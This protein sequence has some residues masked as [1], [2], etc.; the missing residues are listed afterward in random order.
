DGGCVCPPGTALA[1]QDMA[2]QNLTIP[3][4]AAFNAP[5]GGSKYSIVASKL[6]DLCS[7]KSTPE[8][9]LL[10]GGAAPSGGQIG[11][12]SGP[13]GPDCSHSNGDPHMLTVNG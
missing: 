1:G 2:Q 4:V 6:D 12:A 7:G 13:C 11:A 3:F 8:Q 5:E 9:I 10:G